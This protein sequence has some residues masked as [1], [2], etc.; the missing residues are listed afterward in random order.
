MIDSSTD[1]KVGELT[2]KLESL[3][4]GFRIG[5]VAVLL[6]ISLINVSDTV[7]IRWCQQMYQDALPGKPLP[8]ITA[9]LIHYRLWVG[10]FA[11][12]CA[13]AGIY[14]SL[15]IKDIASAIA[16]TTVILV[17]VVFQICITWFFLILPMIG[18]LYIG[19]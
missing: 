17:V 18:S 2:D 4:F 13:G 15:R 10:L 14:T 12:T 7:L 3:S 16:A 11:L 1:A 8:A 6:F 5:T 19:S 9:F